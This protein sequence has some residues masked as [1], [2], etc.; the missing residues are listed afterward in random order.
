[1]TKYI[2]LLS[3][4]FLTLP[5]EGKPL[6]YQI[7]H[8]RSDRLV[9]A[10]PNRM[11]VVAQELHAAP[12]VSAQV[13]VNTG[14]IYEQEHTGAGLSHFL[15]HLLS[16]GSTKNRTEAQSNILL[17]QIGAKTNAATGL[18]TVR[19]Y[20]DT[21]SDHTETVI[22]LLSDWMQNATI[23]QAEYERERQVIQ[24]EFE[25]G[26]GSPGRV[27]WKLT[28][29]ARYT[30]HP[31]R[32]PT[33]GYLDDFLAV[34]RDQINDF[35]HRMYVPNN[36]VFVVAGDIDKQQVID[37]ITRLWASVPAKELPDLSFPVEPELTEPRQV[38]GQATVKRPRL[39]LAWPGT[40]LGGPHDHALDLLG[41]ILGQ[42]ES[43]RL[44]Q[45]LRNKQRL[46]NTI[47]AY[48]LS[49][50]WGQGFFAV[51][52]EMA[53]N[54]TVAEVKAA[55][56]AQVQLLLDQGVTAAELAKAKRKTIASVAY[57]GQSA[58]ALADQLGRD[59]CG[60]ADPDYMTHYAHAIESLTQEDL[61][62]AAKAI[63]VNQ[64]LI[65]VQ[66]LPGEKP[67][68]ITRPTEVVAKVATSNKIVLDNTRRID[69]IQQKMA[70]STRTVT[71][72]TIDPIETFTLDNGL[73]VLVQRSTLVPAVS[74]QMYSLGGLLADT[75]GKEG[76]ANA[77]ASMLTKGTAR[78]SALQIAATQENIGAHLTSHCGNNTSYLRAIC[79]KD[80][81]TTILDLMAD[82]VLNPAF[83]ADE[84]DKLQPRLLAAI[85]RQTDQWQGELQLRFRQSYFGK[86]HPWG[87]LISGHADVV[88]NLTADQL[89]THYQDSLDA[90]QTTLAVF[91]DVDLKE[92]RKQ[93][94]KLFASMPAKA[95]VPFV[96]PKATAMNPGIHQF[97]TSKP[98]AAVQIGLGPGVK[99]TDPDFPKL[100]VLCRVL[101]DF[102]S[103]WLEAQLRGKGPGLAY[104]IWA[105]QVSGMAKGYVA[106]GFNTQ[107]KTAQEAINR[108]QT[109][110]D[111]AREQP[112]SAQDL[113][114]AK[115]AVLTSE[116]LG[117]QSNGDRATQAAL[118]VLYGVGLNDSEQFIKTVKSITPEG[119]GEIAK[120]YLQNSVI[121]VITPEK[122]KITPPS[123]PDQLPK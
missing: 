13:W 77:T 12:V 25:H 46:V 14:S 52:C 88:K 115:A 36:M 105:Y 8:D 55:V 1:M 78:R 44:T 4:L 82:V 38:S 87:S 60:M 81:L 70:A 98:L 39:R 122:E 54:H 23:D 47:S 66:L 86:N 97:Q 80:D 20:I 45:T 62:I 104:A 57:D 116:M 10:L 59:L 95:K 69:R 92:V 94:T 43:S 2:L 17:G 33:I 48:N 29:Q 113:G 3:L 75:P 108:T 99:R 53:S 27:L 119:F 5:A 90:S 76:L 74:V 26:M 68:P 37:Q 72:I 79:L 71:P 110:L 6:A 100:S 93:I 35:Y 84:W 65:E 111:R 28:Q 49:F 118:N 83:P 85:D 106:V 30:S 107:P 121:V 51:D 21:T 109:I 117:K 101:S 64:R 112:I 40:R 120:Q 18:D 34:T 41:I 11:I 42:G 15:E 7:L 24:R 56:L 58:H 114:R 22:D 102:P 31:A 32:Y 63:L 73:R 16:G 123:A 9:V 50:N 103:G 91:G 67:Q 89:R 96:L 61:Q 19:Y